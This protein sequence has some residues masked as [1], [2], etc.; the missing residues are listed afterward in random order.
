MYKVTKLFLKGLLK[1][2]KITEVTSVKFTVG[3]TYK[4]CVGHSSYK[5]IECVAVEGTK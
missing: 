4:A 2:M 3:K 5:I 1:G